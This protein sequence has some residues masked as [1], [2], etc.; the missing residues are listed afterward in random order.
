[1]GKQALLL[2]GDLAHTQKE[3]SEFS[4]FAKLKEFS[5]TRADFLKELESGSYDDVVAL[6][7]SNESTKFTG[8]FDQELVSKLPAS[9]KYICHNGAGYDNIDIAA[10]TNKGI[11]VSSTPVAVNSATADIAIFLMLGA[12]RRIHNPYT[13]V[14]SSQWRGPSFELGR[15][16]QNKVL[17]ILGM[18]GIGREVAVRGRAFG[19]KIQYH[20]RTRLSSSIEQSL[21]ATYVSFEDLLKNADVLSLNCSLRKETVGIIGKKEFGMMKKGVVLVNTARGKLIDEAA[22]VQALEDGSVWSAGLDVYEEEPKIN[23]GL[24]KNPNVV[25]LPHIGTG[26]VETQRN[27]ELLVLENIESAVKKG[28]LI[29]QVSEQ[30]NKSRL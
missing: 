3:W 5:K 25:L 15:D 18:G 26:T 30:E 14:R 13:A 8:E 28:T 23:E 10:C 24:L 12:L 7:R 1:M 16:P 17:G 21:G 22:L 4:S 9:L 2:I 29:T 6:Y 19:M 20:N 11:Q 27:M